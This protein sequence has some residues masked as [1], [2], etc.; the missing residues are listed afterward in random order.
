MAR[1]AR[2]GDGKQV[3][4]PII[5][6]VAAAISETYAPRAGDCAQKRVFERAIHGGASTEVLRMCGPGGL[7]HARIRPVNALERRRRRPR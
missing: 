4:S 5:F 2:R 3:L 1:Q 6:K 7:E